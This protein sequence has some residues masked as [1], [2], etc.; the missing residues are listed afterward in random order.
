MCAFVFLYLRLFISD[1]EQNKTH[2]MSGLENIL[3][4]VPLDFE[5]LTVR[6]QGSGFGSYLHFSLEH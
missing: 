6:K 1:C 5:G 2:E 4:P 3:K